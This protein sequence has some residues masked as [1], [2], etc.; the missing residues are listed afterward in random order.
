MAT[1]EANRKVQQE[2]GV[3]FSW[4]ID[5]CFEITDIKYIWDSGHFKPAPNNLAVFPNI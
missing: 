2:P 5:V 1:Q 3:L 4:D